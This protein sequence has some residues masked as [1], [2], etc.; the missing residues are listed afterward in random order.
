MMIPSLRQ[1]WHAFHH[2]HHLQRHGDID[3]I[4]FAE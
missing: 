2:Q 3:R 1:V 4:D